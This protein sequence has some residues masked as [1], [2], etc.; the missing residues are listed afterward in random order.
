MQLNL[1]DDETA[2][3]L[4]ELD[5]VILNDRFFLSPRIQTLKA[6][7]RRLS[8]TRN[9]SRSHRH[10]RRVLRPEDHGGDENAKT[11]S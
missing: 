6:I 8:P 4:R 9:K 10:C 2:L 3:L 1:T 11:R 7:R 5:N